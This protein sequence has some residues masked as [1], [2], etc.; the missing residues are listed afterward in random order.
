MYC[1]CLCYLQCRTFLLCTALIVLPGLALSNCLLW[2]CENTWNNQILPCLLQNV[3]LN[4]SL[5]VFAHSYAPS[6][7]IYFAILCL[8]FLLYL[9]AVLCALVH[10]RDRL[11]DLSR[12]WDVFNLV[13]YIVC[14]F[15]CMFHV[16]CCV[17]FY[18]WGG[19]HTRLVRCVTCP[20]S[21][22]SSAENTKCCWAS[23]G[24]C[25]SLSIDVSLCVSLCRVCVC[26]PLFVSLLCSLQSC[27]FLGSFNFLSFLDVFPPDVATC[28]QLPASIDHTHLVPVSQFRPVSDFL[29]QLILRHLSI[30]SC[31][32][33]HL[34][35]ALELSTGICYTCSFLFPDLFS[36]HLFPDDRRPTQRWLLPFLW[37]F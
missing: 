34:S 11:A 20:K 27:V 4:L 35:A 22:S 7:T 14:H 33:W 17:S 23:V 30:I 15:F 36:T 24:Y 25:R 32:S 10:I 12:L 8:P 31:R 21:H 13:Y 19:V 5:C 18:A 37:V 9:P 29:F 26:I 16:L 2:F 6:S 28:Y 1:T 3:R